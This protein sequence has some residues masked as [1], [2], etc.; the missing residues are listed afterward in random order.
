MDLMKNEY[1]YN[2]SFR[3]Y[4]DEYCYKNGCSLEDA[5]DDEN[6]KKIL[7]VH[8]GVKSDNRTKNNSRCKKFRRSK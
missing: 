1:R 2:L 3:K 4:V 6:I 8:R 7:Y 5:F